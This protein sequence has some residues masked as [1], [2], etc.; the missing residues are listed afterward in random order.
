M[1]FAKIAINKSYRHVGKVTLLL[2]HIYFCRVL[3]NWQWRAYARRYDLGGG[4]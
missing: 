2:C 4:F 3:A 1:K